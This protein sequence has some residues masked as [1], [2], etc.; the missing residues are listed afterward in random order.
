MKQM[1]LHPQKEMMQLRSII[2]KIMEEY[3]LFSERFAGDEQIVWG[4]EEKY[5]EKFQEGYALIEE[6]I[7]RE[8]IHV[9]RD[10]LKLNPKR[11]CCMLYV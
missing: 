9:L 10:A 2:S 5:L 8:A 6:G 11:G 4:S 7:Y 1:R 3:I